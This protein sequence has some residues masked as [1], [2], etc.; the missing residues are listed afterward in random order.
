M[1]R[2]SV[3]VILP[4]LMAFTLPAQQDPDVSLQHWPQWRGPLFSGAAAQGNPPVEFGESKN[5]KWKVRIPGKGHSTPVVWGDY[6]VVTTAV[7]TDRK[8]PKGENRQEGMRVGPPST[9]TEFIHRF[10]V[11]LVNRHHGEILWT[12]TV[13]EEFPLE[14]THDLGSWASNSPITDGERIYAYF[15]S[16]GIHCLDFKG[17]VIWSKDFG[18]MEKVMSF[19]EG[20]SPA[21]YDNRLVIV[22]DH[23]GE[24][25]IVT[26]DARTG[27]ELWRVKRD[28]Q[29]SWST[30]L[31]IEAG[32]RNQVITSATKKVRSYDLADGSL[33]W[34]STG[35]TRNVIPNPVYAHG[36]LYIMSGYR[37]AAL[38][39]ID[40]TIASG[41]VQ[42]TPALLREYNQDTPYTPAPLLMDGLLYFLRNN[43]GYLTC[44]DARTGEVKYAS[45]K[46]EGINAIYSSPTGAAGRICFAA[47]GRAVVV[48]AGPEFK[49]LASNALDDTFHASPIVVGDAL[50]LRGFEYLYCFQE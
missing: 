32:G 46:I 48:Q 23:E 29:S 10:N 18:Q 11:M 6:L 3:T 19:G 27:E 39:A 28:E 40:P 33:I 5:L 7:P 14:R 34:E 35:M 42:G 15:G 4:L 16:R 20:S 12:T 36:V 49:M 31:V 37:G 13:A 2:I 43:N 26:L 41:T 21:L 44:M 24:S 45:Q 8:P 50:Y 25:F 30:P 17:N 1:K 9:G 38:Q 22:W 47:T